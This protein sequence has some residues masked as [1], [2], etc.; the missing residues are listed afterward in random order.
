MSISM[1]MFVIVF[2]RGGMVITTTSWILSLFHFLHAHID[3]IILSNFRLL[4]EI[5]K[6]IVVLNLFA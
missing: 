1:R 6:Y 3:G 5:N 2:V 4:F